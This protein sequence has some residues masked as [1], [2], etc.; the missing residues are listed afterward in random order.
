MH[1]LGL[2]SAPWMC[3]GVLIWLVLGVSTTNI[4]NGMLGKI[5]S[6]SNKSVTFILEESLSKS[7]RYDVGHCVI[8]FELTLLGCLLVSDDDGTCK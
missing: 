1:A 6:S 3:A 4:G 8:R 5:V 2:L 7:Q